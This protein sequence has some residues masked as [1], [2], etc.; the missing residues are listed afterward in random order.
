MLRRA[1][2][3]VRRH[4]ALA[5]LLLCGVVAGAA[6]FWRRSPEK[7]PGAT[8]AWERYL[9]GRKL[10]RHWYKDEN[11]DGAIRLFDEATKPYSTFALAFARLADTQ[12]TRHA[13]THD[14]DALAAA[15]RNVDEAVRLKA[16]LAPVQVALG[17]IRGARGNNDLA[18]AAF[19]RALALDSDDAEAN[20]AI[21]RQYE[22]LGRLQDA[23]AS[24]RKAISLDPE[25]TFIIDSYA[26]FLFRRVRFEEAARQ[27]QAVIRLTPENAPAFV[28]LGAA[29]SEN[30][31]F[32][33]AIAMFER[34]VRLKPAYLG[35]N[36][37]QEAVKAYREALARE[38]FARAIELAETARKESPREEQLHCDLATHYAKTNQPRLAV[39]RLE[40]AIALAPDV[41][42]VQASAAE[43]YE[44]L[45]QRKKA[46]ELARKAIE[47]GFPWQ[48]LQRSPEL[49]RLVA[50]VG[51][52]ATP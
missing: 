37:F 33:E 7:V 48:R 9:E 18:F 20:Q 34:A 40:T 31:N 36:R 23:E 32:P 41:A 13:L 3:R 26:N 30:G 4:G 39:E 12:R 35:A 28:N 5:A 49:A 17:R 24:F 11:L 10:A 50:D 21:A 2:D 14:Q 44:L 46:V 25:S 42:T 27:W 1:R 22:R 8:Q 19:E 16:E 51:T 43:V 45:G 15:V 47:L 52:R 38:T 6:F 29:L